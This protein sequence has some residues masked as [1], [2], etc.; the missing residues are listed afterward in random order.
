[1]KNPRPR[2]QSGELGQ[3]RIGSWTGQSL[4]VPAPRAQHTNWCRHLYAPRP[5][6]VIDD[7]PALFEEYCAAARH[8]QQS[9]DLGDGIAAGKAWRRFLDAFLTEDA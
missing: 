5:V 3:Q 9:H 2:R 7:A 1:M 6:P 8:A 4:H